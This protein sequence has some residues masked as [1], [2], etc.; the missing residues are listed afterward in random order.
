M[1]SAV[2]FLPHF[3]KAPFP[4]DLFLLHLDTLRGILSV[5]LF[6]RLWS[7]CANFILQTDT[8]RSVPHFFTKNG[9]RSGGSYGNSFEI[10]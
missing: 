10:A 8:Y 5:F 2:S 4:M 1:D 7:Y 3:V 9:K 6:F